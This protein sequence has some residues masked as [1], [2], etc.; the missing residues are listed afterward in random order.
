MGAAAELRAGGWVAGVAG[1]AGVAGAHPPDTLY[2][3]QY[4]HTAQ[5]PD[6]WAG[7]HHH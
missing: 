1:M 3:M 5:P 2:R 4:P 7:I 6:P